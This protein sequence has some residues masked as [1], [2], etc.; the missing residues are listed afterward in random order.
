MQAST[1]IGGETLGE[2]RA[3]L[4]EMV[5]NLDGET[6]ANI[7]SGAPL[8]AC[9]DDVCGKIPAARQLWIEITQEEIEFKALEQDSGPHSGN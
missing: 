4:S 5:R 7:M 2:K 8:K 9:P 6:I 3:R 1:V